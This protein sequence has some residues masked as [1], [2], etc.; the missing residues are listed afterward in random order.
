V[1]TKLY[2][3]WT[4]SPFYNNHGY[5]RND[6]EYAFCKK[7]QSR[8]TKEEA[9][10]AKEYMIQHVDADMEVRIKYVETVKQVIV[11]QF[12]DG[13]ITDVALVRDGETPEQ[14]FAR[15][16]ESGDVDDTD[17]SYETTTLTE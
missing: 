2:T 1:A 8:F 11:I 16:C 15:R 12:N 4:K 17:Y 5:I 7:W 14:T 9:D 13:T 3:V 10:A 6:D